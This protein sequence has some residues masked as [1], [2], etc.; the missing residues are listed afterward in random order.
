MLPPEHTPK[1][2]WLPHSLNAFFDLGTVGSEPRF[3]AGSRRNPIKLNL[4]E[5][6]LISN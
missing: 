3:C 2:G 1:P 4:W 6:D 5:H